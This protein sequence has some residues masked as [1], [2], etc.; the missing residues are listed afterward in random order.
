MTVNQYLLKNNSWF[1]LQHMLKIIL[2]EKGMVG[3][4]AVFCIVIAKAV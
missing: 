2:D 3:G 1:L 4:G